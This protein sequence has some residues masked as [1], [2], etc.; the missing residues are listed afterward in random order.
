MNINR[1]F[2]II[3]FIVIIP[4][5]EFIQKQIKIQLIIPKRAFDFCIFKNWRNILNTVFHLEPSHDVSLFSVFNRND[6]VQR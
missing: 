5:D 4:T 6:K 3:L 1:N 2:K